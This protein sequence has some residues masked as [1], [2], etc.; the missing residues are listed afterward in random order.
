MLDLRLQNS[1]CGYIEPSDR[2]IWYFS[3]I[4]SMN[5]PHPQ[6][7]RWLDINNNTNNIYKYLSLFVESFTTG[8]NR[9]LSLE[10]KWKCL[11]S[12]LRLLSILVYLRSQFIHRHP[13]LSFSLEKWGLYI[14]IYIII[15]MS[16]HEHGYPWPSL[17]TFPYRSSPLSGLQ[18]YIPYPHIAVE[19]MF[20]LVVLLLP[21]HMW[22]SIRV[23]HLWA[24]PCFS[25][26]VLHI[27]FV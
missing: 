12:S 27:W 9:W 21:G 22:G 18:G 1:K 19:C 16:C 4:L 2:F 15:I 14:Y 3:Y 23:H 20:V 17:A 11:F 26:S 8:T 10:S 5:N 24:R 6:F 7:G 25:S 13:V